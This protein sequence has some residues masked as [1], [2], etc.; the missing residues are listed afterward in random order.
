MLVR[1]TYSGVAIPSKGIFLGKNVFRNDYDMVKHEFGHVLQYNLHGEL[2]YYSIIAPESFVNA[3][4]SKTDMEHNNFWTETY[5]NY[6]SYNYFKTKY[7]CTSWNLKEYP[8]KS[9]SF[10]NR[11]RLY[12]LR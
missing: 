4:M 2:A 9:I 3:S 12:L 1:Q 11:L 7:N 8:I 10:F 6:L 5:A